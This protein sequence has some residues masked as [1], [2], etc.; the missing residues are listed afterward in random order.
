MLANALD[1]EL[2]VL[3]GGLG[4]TPVFRARVEAA[5]RPL[6][7]YPPVPELVAAALGPD[8]GIVGAALRAAEGG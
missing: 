8:G 4:A 7:A 6:L 3:G 2:V 5:F 1:P